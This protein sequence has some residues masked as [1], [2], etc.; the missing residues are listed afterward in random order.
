MSLA[1]ELRSVHNRA[2]AR[3]RELEPLVAEYEELKRLV[4]RMG[5]AGEAPA[6]RPEAPPAAAAPSAP[7]AA[8][9]AARPRTEAD[10]REA[11]VVEVVRAEPGLTVAQIGERMGQAPTSLYRVVRNLTSAG[12]LVKRGRALFPAE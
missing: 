12:T 8:L 7:A 11:R 9:P 6:P 3:L 10:A 5:L 1:D 2:L 4:D